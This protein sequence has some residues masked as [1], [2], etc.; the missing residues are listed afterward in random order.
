M[1]LLEGIFKM[2]QQA[3]KVWNI[4]STPSFVINNKFM[5]AGNLS[6]KKFEDTF[7]KLDT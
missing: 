7:K 5:L 1:E 4:Q 3:E 2:R 6:I